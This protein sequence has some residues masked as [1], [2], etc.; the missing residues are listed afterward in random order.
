MGYMEQIS[1]A[2]L[3]LNLLDRCPSIDAGLDLLSRRLKAR[4]GM[5]NMLITSF[6]YDFLSS[7]LEYQWK[8]LH[9]LM[10]KRGVVHCTEEEYEKLNQDA[11]INAVQPVNSCCPLLPVSGN[12]YRPDRCGD[13]YV[14]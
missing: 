10:G 9:G 7:E 2:S 3:A 13:P 11:Q 5:E 12:R 14:R 4:Y 1:L 6:H 8:H